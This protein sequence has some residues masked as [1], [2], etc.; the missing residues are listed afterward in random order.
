MKFMKYLYDDTRTLYD[1]FRRGARVSSEFHFIVTTAANV[2]WS[3]LLIQFPFI[4][5]MDLVWDG[6]KVLTHST[7]G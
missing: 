5:T 1:V 7:N 4:K 2:I 6:E 3:F